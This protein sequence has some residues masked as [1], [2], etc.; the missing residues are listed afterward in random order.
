MAWN[1]QSVAQEKVS[2]IDTSPSLTLSL[3]KPPSVNNLFFN[4][5]KR[6]RIASP[7]YKAWRA[8]ASYQVRAQRP[9]FF[10]GP[11]TLILVIEESNRCDLDNCLKAPLDLLVELGILE[12]DGPRIVKEIKVR[13]GQV[14][15]ALVTITAYNDEGPLFQKNGA[16]A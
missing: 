3:P 5:P 8:A 12:D 6:G 4:L 9:L 13:H 11:V 7:E 16:R 1:K 2:P 14:T 10:R 15:G